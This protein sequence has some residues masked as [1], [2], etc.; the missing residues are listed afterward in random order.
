MSP[1]NLYQVQADALIQQLKREQE[2]RCRD[3]QATGE[4]W[5]RQRLSEARHQALIRFRRAAKQERERFSREISAA[6]AAISAE[7]RNR[8]QHH[9]SAM[10]HAVIARLPGA[11]EARW[12]ESSSRAA[13]IDAALLDA[14]Q[15]MGPGEWHVRI[16]AASDAQELPASRGDA[17]ITWS[18]DHRLK[19]GLVIEKDGAH[20]DASTTGLLADTTLLE[21]RILEMLGE[22]R[23]GTST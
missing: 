13:W 12:N 21:S 1:A 20:L 8:H 5:T 22:I 10:V 3:L 14:Q 9:L 11:L 7:A 16:A 15:R 23:G 18:Q 2:K 6:E 19:A 4:S 17:N